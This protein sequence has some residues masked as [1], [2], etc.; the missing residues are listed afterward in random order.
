M[1]RLG[2]GPR[3]LA[4]AAKT[5]ALLLRGLIP[6]RKANAAGRYE[7]LIDA[8]RACPGNAPGIAR[9]GMPLPPIAQWPLQRSPSPLNS[10]A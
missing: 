1:A 8:G 10:W 9:G 3:H 4:G 6:T 7:W 5:D 2:S